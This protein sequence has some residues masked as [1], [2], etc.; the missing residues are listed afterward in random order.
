MSDPSRQTTPT[1]EVLVAHI[2]ANPGPAWDVLTKQ[3]QTIQGL[4]ALLCR[5][6]EALPA[7]YETLRR[8]IAAAVEETNEPGQP[9][10]LL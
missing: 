1:R 6:S 9:G 2:A 5:A 7:C 8:D 4:R 10:S 3:D